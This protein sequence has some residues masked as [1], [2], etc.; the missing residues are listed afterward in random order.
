[1]YFYLPAVSVIF[2]PNIARDINRPITTSDSTQLK[3]WLG[4][5]NGLVIKNYKRTTTK[6]S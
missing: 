6:T 3:P 1:M 4:K 5:L 2:Y